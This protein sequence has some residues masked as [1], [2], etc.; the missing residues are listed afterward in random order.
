MGSKWVQALLPS[1]GM[2]ARQQ[3]DFIIYLWTMEKVLKFQVLKL[4]RANF[5]F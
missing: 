2:V 4:L 3:I 1:L 5:I